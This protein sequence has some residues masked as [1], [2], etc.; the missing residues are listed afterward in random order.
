M[1]LVIAIL[2]GVAVAL[3]LPESHVPH[4]GFSLR[5]RPIA[6]N[7]LSVAKER[8]FLTYGLAG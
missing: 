6:E 5:L 8:Q 1:L 7:F 2:L 3:T 4:P